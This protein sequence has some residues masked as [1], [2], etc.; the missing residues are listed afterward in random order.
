VSHSVIYETQLQDQGKDIVL[1][2]PDLKKP[3]TVSQKTGEIFRPRSM[4]LMTGTEARYVVVVIRFSLVWIAYLP[5][6]RKSLTGQMTEGY[7]AERKR[8]EQHML[9]DRE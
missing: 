8:S 2:L 4:S 1:Q 9:I 5:Q 6:P 3:R 7:K